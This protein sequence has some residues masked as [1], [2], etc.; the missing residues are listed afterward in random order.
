MPEPSRSRIRLWPILTLL[1]MAL[2]L[3]VL[4]GA[5]AFDDPFVTYRYAWNAAQG[6]G[7]LYNS[8]ERVLSTTAPLYALVLAAVD[9]LAQGLLG[10]SPALALL[11]AVSNGLSTASLFVAACFLYLYAATFKKPW[12][13]WFAAILFITAPLLWLSLGFEMG[14]YL[15]LTLGAF[16]FYASR[17]FSVASALLALALLTRGDGILPAIVLAG[18]YLATERGI[19]WRAA[20]V[21]GVVAAPFLLYLTF[22][23][24]SPLP[25][26][27]AAKSAQANLGVTGFYAGTTFAQG[28]RILGLAYV[29][30]SSLYLSFVP[31]IVLGLVAALKR[32]RWLL[33]VLLWAVAHFCS[34]SALGVA[35]YHW[36]YAP[37]LPAVALLTAAG[38]AKT[39]NKVRALVRGERLRSV[40][41]AALGLVLTMPQFVSNAQIRQALLHPSALQPEETR[42]KVLPEAKVAVYRR[43][44][45]WLREN[46]PEDALVGVTEV[47]IIG[48]YSERTMVDFLG[49]LRP[50]VVDALRRGDMAWALLYYQ[51]D[52]VVL[53]RVNPLYSYDLSRDDWF[54]QAYVPLHVFE[55]TSFW[56]GPV[57][58]YRRQTPRAEHLASGQ[59][60]AEALPL[61]VRFGGGIELAAYSLDRVSL[62]P[63]EVLNITLYWTCLA[64]VREDYTVFVHLLGQHELIIA[65]R[66]AYPCLGA[67]PTRGWGPGEIRIDTHMLAVP[68]TA[69]T[70]DEAQVEVGLYE[71]TTGRRL[72]ATEAGGAAVGDNVRFGRLPVAPAMAA[73]TPNPMSINWGDDIALVGYDIDRRAVQP[74]QSVHLTLYWRGLRAMQ[75]DYSVFAHVLSEGG[76]RMA[77]ADGWP[78]HGQAPTSEWKPGATVLDEYDLR[79]P[80]DAPVGVYSIYLGLYVSETGK[81][82]PVLDVSGQP[83]TNEIVLTRMRVLD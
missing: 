14:F 34:Y 11:P 68:V 32:E 16:Y 37:L 56:A 83:Q 22:T 61:H 33:P 71:G 13:G 15:A 9:L 45:D 7:L 51:P 73:M 41:V 46:T 30:Q 18:H 70:P 43:V 67:C 50:Q 42:Y 38:V 29:S 75:E 65:Q 79:L 21:Y 77:Q 2:L 58:V 72:A 23:F 35:P 26:T 54:K 49:L 48:Y 59:V 36:Y 74:G 17:R 64:P 6:N 28:A 40:V 63:G 76:Q 8:G 20:A 82:L 53:T 27:L 66:D 62:R 55:D 78:Q 44:G 80:A 3:G 10:S 31:L 4:L 1:G 52:Y 19:P 12:V 81:R 39:A 57:T 60:P 25:V 69:Y 24:G 5:I 47:G